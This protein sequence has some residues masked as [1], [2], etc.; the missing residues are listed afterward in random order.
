MLTEDAKPEPMPLNPPRPSDSMLGR[1][2]AA[3]DFGVP[4]EPDGLSNWSLRI[5]FV[6]AGVIVSESI[7]LA[8]YAFRPVR[9]A[10]GGEGLFALFTAGFAIAIV[11]VF[12]VLVALL[13]RHER[14]S[15]AARRR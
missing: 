14:R 2:E 11:L 8:I 9:P 10:V 12:A 7:L 13:A 6:A 15:E 3:E 4:L 1:S 5:L